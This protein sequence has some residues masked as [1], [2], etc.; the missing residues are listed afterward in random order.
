MQLAKTEEETILTANCVRV[1]FPMQ[2]LDLD[3]DRA[4]SVGLIV[5][6]LLTNALKYAFPTGQLGRIS[7]S[8]AEVENGILEL[9]IADNGIGKTPNARP[10]GTGFGTQLVDLLTRQ[11]DG[12]LRQE[13][14]NGTAISIR[15]A[16]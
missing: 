4:I 6:E 2:P 15:F 13:V 11:L 9:K 8:L 3:V 5:N 12:T 16:R 7:L 10:Q 1:E 14:A